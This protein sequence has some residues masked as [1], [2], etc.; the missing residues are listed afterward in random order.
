MIQSNSQLLLTIEPIDEPTTARC[1]LWKDHLDPDITTGIPL[2]RQIDDSA[3]ITPQF[4]LDGVSAKTIAKQ[5]RTRQLQSLF[6]LDRRQPGQV[7]KKFQDSLIEITI[8]LT[9]IVHEHLS[10]MDGQIRI[11][12][13][14]ALYMIDVLIHDLLLKFKFQPSFENEGDL[15]S[16]TSC[17]RP[18]KPCPRNL[19]LFEFD[20]HLQFVQQPYPDESP[21]RRSALIQKP[22]DRPLCISGEGGPSIHEPLE[23]TGDDLWLHRGGDTISDTLATI[24]RNQL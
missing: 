20:P 2:T 1:V 23:I 8:A 13:E 12:I 6:S 22:E 15:P 14:V 4:L 9:E 3:P 11:L 5:T 10:L 24:A 18:G 7:S 19:K 16:G 21:G 17:E